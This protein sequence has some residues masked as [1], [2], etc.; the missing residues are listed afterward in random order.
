MQML[1]TPKVGAASGSELKVGSAGSSIDRPIGKWVVHIRSR[2]SCT[3]GSCGY[4]PEGLAL[5]MMPYHM[6]SVY[7][8]PVT[9][10]CDD[11]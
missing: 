6:I 5:L 2:G 10:P 3:L 4:K 9:V 8:Y 7:Q 11:V 1:T